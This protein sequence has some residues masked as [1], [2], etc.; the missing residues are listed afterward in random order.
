MLVKYVWSIG[1]PRLMSVLTSDT[2][3]NS[4]ASPP[5]VVLPSIVFAIICLSCSFS[6]RPKSCGPNLISPLSCVRR[7]AGWQGAQEP[8]PASPTLRPKTQAKR[9][10]SPRTRMGKNTPEASRKPPG[11]IPP[12]RLLRRRAPQP[13]NHNEHDE[14]E[15]K[16]RHAHAHA[17]HPT[18]T[19]ERLPIAPMGTKAHDLRRRALAA[20]GS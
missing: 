11:P 6:T 5:A 15:S 19:M 3:S 9:R 7:M 10:P 14:R 2:R 18:R 4:S 12:P 17:Q 1:V 8:T 20:R 13:P 16:A